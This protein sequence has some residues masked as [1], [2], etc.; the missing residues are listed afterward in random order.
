MAMF[1]KDKSSGDPIAP[2]PDVVVPVPPSTPAAVVPHADANWVK[3]F[4]SA[5]GA[6]GDAHTAESQADEAVKVLER[7]GG[8]L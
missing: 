4:M 8:K 7:R 5:F 3:L 1:N 2:S 6:R